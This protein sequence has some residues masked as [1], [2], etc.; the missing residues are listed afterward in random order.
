VN[1]QASY[2]AGAADIVEGEEGN[3][4]SAIPDSWKEAN[5]WTY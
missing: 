5:L 2:R 1:Y 4:T 3:Y